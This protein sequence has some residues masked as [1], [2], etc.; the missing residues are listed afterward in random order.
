[1]TEKTVE[2]DGMDIRIEKTDDG[3]T[4]E[5]VA[6]QNMDELVEAVAAACPSDAD[7]SVESG[8]IAVRSPGLFTSQLKDMKALGLSLSYVADGRV[9]FVHDQLGNTEYTYAYGSDGSEQ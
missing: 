7:V 2:L 6:P 4:A 5:P 3:I 1:M 9:L 8:L